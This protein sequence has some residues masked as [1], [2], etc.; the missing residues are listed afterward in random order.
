MQPE[1]LKL[2]SDKQGP[3]TFAPPLSN[4]FEKKEV[5]ALTV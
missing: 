1:K 3:E 4:H 5:Q 2:D